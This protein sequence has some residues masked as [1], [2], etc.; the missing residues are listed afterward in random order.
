M[1][2]LGFSLILSLCLIGCGDDGGDGATDGDQSSSSGGGGGG[3]STPDN[4]C[5]ADGYMAANAIVFGGTDPG[6]AY[7]PRCVSVSV[8]D[9]VTWTGDFG[10]HPIVGGYIDGM[11]KVPDTSSP[12]GGAAAGSMEL[13]VTFTE[14]GVFPFY[15]NP[16]GPF[17][18][19]GA[20]KVE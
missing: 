5:S 15:C 16:H 18:M 12:I 19:N 10:I 9:T 8:G 17:G 2:A 20:V 13:M 6:L 14:A 4:D 11:D 3:G 7:E 1:R